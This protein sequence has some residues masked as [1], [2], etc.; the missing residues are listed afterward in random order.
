MP[1]V[2]YYIF[3]GIWLDKIDILMRCSHFKWD[4]NTTTY[5]YIILTNHT[6]A[7][8]TISS[9]Y[10]IVDPSH[11]AE[12]CYVGISARYV[13]NEI[14]HSSR[15]VEFWYWFTQYTSTRYPSKLGSGMGIHPLHTRCNILDGC[16]PIHT[17]P[18]AFTL[19]CATLILTPP[20]SKENKDF[21]FDINIMIVSC[22][23]AHHT[24]IIRQNTIVVIKFMQ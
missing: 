3:Y 23:R 22:A 18:S 14:Q 12:F 8:S 24:W 6:I 11:D 5:A 21:H 13:S 20:G 9:K 15:I 7:E 10:S 1:V 16:H 19:E 2:E 17:H 4:S